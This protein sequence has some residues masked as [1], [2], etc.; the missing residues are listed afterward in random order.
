MGLLGGGRDQ[1]E[2][3]LFSSCNHVDCGCCD[4]K[5]CHLTIGFKICSFSLQ[6]IFYFKELVY[7]HLRRFVPI[8]VRF[9]GCFLSRNVVRHIMGRLGGRG[10]NVHV[11]MQC[12]PLTAMLTFLRSVNCH[13]QGHIQ[14]HSMFSS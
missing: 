11:Q 13:T 5:N 4:Q 1:A 9:A 2:P 10:L 14:K 6:M 7:L 3:K 8:F 12:D